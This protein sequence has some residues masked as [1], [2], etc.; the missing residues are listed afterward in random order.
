MGSASAR[1]KVSC[2]LFFSFQVEIFP[3]QDSRIKWFSPFPIWISSFSHADDKGKGKRGKDEEGDEKEST[4]IHH[5]K[6]TRKWRK[7]S[8]YILAKNNRN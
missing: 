3:L 8:N 5:H 1:K 6:N 2:P 7:K 4:I